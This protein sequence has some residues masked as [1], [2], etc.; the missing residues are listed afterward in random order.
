MPPE[1]GLMRSGTLDDKRGIR[2]AMHESA[3][4]PPLAGTVEVDEVF[5]GGKP[6]HYREVV[7]R[8]FTLLR[9]IF[10]AIQQVFQFFRQRPGELE[11]LFRPG[12]RQ[13]QH[14]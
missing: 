4:D 14:R 2:F 5:I 7:P 9:S 8:S 10:Q 6:R 12:M 11:Q 3:N 1:D 13:L